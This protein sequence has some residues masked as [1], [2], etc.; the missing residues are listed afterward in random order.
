M[1]NFGQLSYYLIAL[2]AKITKNNNM[3]NAP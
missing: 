2:L 3:A 1:K